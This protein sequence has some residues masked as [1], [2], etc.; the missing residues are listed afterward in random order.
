M[1]AAPGQS[2]KLVV[3][4][5]DGQIK[6][7]DL[8]GVPLENIQGFQI[9]LHNGELSLVVRVNPIIFAG[10]GELVDEVNIVMSMIDMVQA[11]RSQGFLVYNPTEKQG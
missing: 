9:T 6:I 1:N 3:R 2:N 11:I 10:G 7:C 8:N 4:I 5:D